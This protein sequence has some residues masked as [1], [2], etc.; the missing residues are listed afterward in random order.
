MSD[1]D[2]LIKSSIG[3]TIVVII[4]YIL[5]FAKEAVFAAYYG[6][7]FQADAFVVAIQ[8]PVV[9]FALVAV[10]I[11]TV[12]LPIYT[13]RLV[14]VGQEHA[15]IFARNL[16]T[17]TL[18]ISSCFV[19][20]GILL[21]DQIVYLFAPGFDDQTHNLTVMLLKISFPVVFF[22]IQTDIY[23]AVLNAWRVFSW[24]QMASYFQNIMLIAVVFVLIDNLGI[25][26]AIIGTLLGAIVQCIYMLVLSRKYFCYRP[27]LN[28]KDADIHQAGKMVVPVVIGIGVAEINCFIDRII[29]SGL[30]VGSISSI[31]YA[32]KLNG[33]FS[34]LLVHPIATVVFPSFSRLVIKKDY[35]ELNRLINSIISILVLTILPLTVG[36]IL[37]NV[38]LVSIVFGRGVF[39]NNAVILT[40]NILIYFNIGLLFITVREII[41]R[42]YYSFNDTKTPMINA[43]I[44]VALNIV[45]NILLSRLMG[46]PGLALATSISSAFICGLLLFNLKNKYPGYHLKDVK[47]ALIKAIVATIGMIVILILFECLVSV[48]NSLLYLLC[49]LAVGAIAYIGLL[50][51]LRTREAFTLWDMSLKYVKRIRIKSISNKSIYYKGGNHVR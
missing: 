47:V 12:T 16:L 14:E 13:K 48:S 36:L 50:F 46:A 31:N 15:A 41:S 18:I 3:I 38:E 8:I 35:N 10:G 42:V 30:S 24:P 32:S 44:G 45:L 7:S 9:L 23:N 1:T 34:T 39:D 17:I 6:V 28:L 49:Y 29:A 25:Y 20:L 4:G 22:T 19:T 43:S 5:S 51:V 33:I 21:A 2:K 27:Y 11:R 40:G 37:C 26:A